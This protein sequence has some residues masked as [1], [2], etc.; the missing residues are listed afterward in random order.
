MI[1]HGNGQSETDMDS[2]VRRTSHTHE[3]R[4]EKEMLSWICIE[5]AYIRDNTAISFDND[6]NEH[7]VRW[8]RWSRFDWDT[9]V[10]LLCRCSVCIH[11]PQWSMDK[12]VRW[13]RFLPPSQLV[14]HIFW[15]I[16]STAPDLTVRQHRDAGHR[17][18]CFASSTEQMALFASSDQVIHERCA[19]IRQH[20]VLCLATRRHTHPCHYSIGRIFTHRK[21][22]RPLTR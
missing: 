1:C 20:P 11:L 22:L 8:S 19:W 12:H 13:T 2:A 3:N 21:W 5:R 7:C 16:S 15:A 14:S 4:K 18:N 6:G 17:S 9:V 10:S